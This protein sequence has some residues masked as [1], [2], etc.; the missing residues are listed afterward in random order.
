MGKR[1]TVVLPPNDDLLGGPPIEVVLRIREPLAGV[2]AEWLKSASGRKRARARF[3]E[4]EE[5]LRSMLLA[6]VPV[7][8]ERVSQGKSVRVRRLGEP[9]KTFYSPPRS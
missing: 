2:P 6:G 4:N 8:I 3:R 5:K 1:R 9:R 7:R